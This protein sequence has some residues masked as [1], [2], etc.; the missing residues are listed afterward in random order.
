ML[1]PRDVTPKS[2]MPN[3]P[4]LFKKKTNYKVLT[5]KLSVMKALGVPYTDDQIKNAHTDALKQAHEII[6]DLASNGVDKN[7]ENKEIVAL[8]AYLQRLGKDTADK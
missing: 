6:T 3:Y 2:I 1:N 8:I 7:I 4:W 5:K